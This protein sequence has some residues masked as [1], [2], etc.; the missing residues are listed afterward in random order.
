MFSIR[1]LHFDVEFLGSEETGK[2]FLS[3]EL[4]CGIF[5]EILLTE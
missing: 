2:G 1:N 4:C 3:V 5:F